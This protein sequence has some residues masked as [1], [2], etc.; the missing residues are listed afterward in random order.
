MHPKH[1]VR[2][3]SERI[4]RASDCGVHPFPRHAT[5]KH[6]YFRHLCTSFFVDLVSTM[7]FKDN[8]PPHEDVVE[9]LLSLL[10]VQK[11]LLRDAPQSKSLSSRSPD[12]R[13]PLAGVSDAN[14]ARA[15]LSLV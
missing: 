3:D 7:C 14:G 1:C 2:G 5:E 9:A 10:F 11:T 8:C 4:P 6:A 12:S 15:C 13:V